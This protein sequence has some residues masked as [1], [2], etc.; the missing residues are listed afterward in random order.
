MS[1]LVF[2]GTAHTL[3]LFDARGNQ[4]GQWPAN[5]LVDHAYVAKHHGLPFIPNGQYPIQD[6]DR[7]APHKHDR[8]GRNGA[9]DSLNGAYGRFG[10][11]RLKPF[12][13]GKHWHSG[14]A[15]HSGRAD[16]G[17]QNHATHGC[18]R[19]TDGAVE[20][21]M[22]LM[23]TDPLVSV[24]VQNNHDQHHQ[25]RHHHPRHH[26]QSAP[27]TPPRPATPNTVMV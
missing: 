2:D 5:N 26:H 3:T 7:S 23:Q 6:E 10:V 18:I 13:V 4:V 8:H 24:T 1:S 9:E 16:A 25:P 15:V 21:I 11:I 19:T 20:G 12:K 14:V 17:A 22:D 27:A